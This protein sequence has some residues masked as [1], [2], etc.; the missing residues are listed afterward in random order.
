VH[1]ERPSFEIKSHLDTR[2]IFGLQPATFSYSEPE[3][4]QGY[5][6]RANVDIVLRFMPSIS[7]Q[8][9]LFRFSGQNFVLCGSDN[10]R[11]GWYLR[12]VCNVAWY[13]P[14]DVT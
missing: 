5:L 7:K 13:S 14:D 12:T 2:E 11:L 4:L 9:V 10:L 8:S 6:F 1:G 3:E